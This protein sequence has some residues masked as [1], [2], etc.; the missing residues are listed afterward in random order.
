MPNQLSHPGAQEVGFEDFRALP[1]ICGIR[2][3]WV[4]PGNLRFFLKFLRRFYSLGEVCAS[5]HEPPVQWHICQWLAVPPT[6]KCSWLPETHKA[7]DPCL[8]AHVHSRSG[9]S[10]SLHPLSASFRCSRI[11]CL[12]SQSQ[13]NSHITHDTS[14]PKVEGDFRPQGSAV[15]ASASVYVAHRVVT[16]LLLECTPL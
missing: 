15:H 12:F 9:M 2:W 10:S 16:G 1:Y 5:C 6:K 4:G 7:F 8:V 3:V 14:G 11:C 13:V